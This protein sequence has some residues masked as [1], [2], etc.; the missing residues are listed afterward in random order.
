MH[1]RNVIG[2]ALMAMAAL[3]ACGGGGDDPAPSSFK[4][5]QADVKNVA[6]LGVLTSAL[7]GT[8]VAPGLDSLGATLQELS[9]DTGGSRSVPSTTCVSEGA[10]SGSFSAEVVKTAAHTGFTTGDKITLVYD[11]CDFG[12]QGY[13]M[14][15]TVT[16]TSQSAAVNLPSDNYSVSFETNATGLSI[17]FDGLTTRYNGLANVV[18]GATS[19]TAVTT[20]FTVP[21]GRTF[22]IVLSMAQP[23]FSMT[24]GAGTTF[25]RTEDTANQSSS[26]KLDG[27]VNAGAA[28]GTVPL[29]IATPTKLEGTTS[30]ASV[31]VGTSGVIATKSTAQNLATSTTLNGA[32]AT[33]S[34]DTDGNGSLD[35]VFDTTWVALNTP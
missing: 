18:A 3:S 11:K 35:L 8:R 10:G 1:R 2:T 27:A 22:D 17:K 7:T 32:N 14:D 16:V 6:S 13:V 12:G 24:Y 26:V 25:A 9:T 34:G 19:A 15:G 31:F 21:A 30:E 20:S 5:T 28:I 29:V 4:A 33:V 23:T